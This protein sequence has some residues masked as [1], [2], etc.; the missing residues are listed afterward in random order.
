[1]TEDEAEIGSIRGII[2]KLNETASHVIDEEEKANRRAA[3]KEADDQAIQGSEDGEGEEG[4]SSP[5]ANNRGAG[6]LS[7]PND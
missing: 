4:A 2:H 3:Q 1:M 7:V 5:Q 6:T